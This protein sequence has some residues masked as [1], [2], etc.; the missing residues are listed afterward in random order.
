[1]ALDDIIQELKFR[2]KI[3]DVVSSYNIQLKRSSRN[4]VG[5]CPFHGEKTPSFNLYPENNSFYCFGCH[6]GGDVIT[7]IR[8]MENLDYVD[9][10]K[11]LAQRYNIDIP[12]STKDKGLSNLRN[13]IYEANKEAARYF[14][15]KL[16]TQE[17]QNALNYLKGRGLTEQTIKHF[18]LGYSTSITYDLTSYLNDKGF[19]NTELIQANLSFESRS[20][21]IVDRFID[22]IM[23]PIMDLRGNVIAFGGRIMTDQKPKYLNTSDTPV[24]KKSNNCFALSFA[25]NSKDG[26]L[27]LAEGYMDVI[28][29]HQAGFESA[30]ATLGTALTKEQAI[31]LKRYTDDIV[32]CYDSDDAGQNATMRAIPILRDVGLNVRVINIPNG[33]DPDEFLKTN[34]E[35]GHIKFKQLIEKSGNDIEYRLQKL[36]NKLDLDSPDGKVAY[37]TQVSK[38]L[39]TFDSEIEIDVYARKIAAELS[40]APY[41]IIQQIDKY[42][43]KDYKTKI[44]QQRNKNNMEVLVVND[45]INPDKKTHLMASNAEEQIISCIINNPDIAGSIIS[46]F[47]PEKFI[48]SF[49]KKIYECIVRR[50]NDKKEFSVMDISGEFSNDENSRIIKIVHNYNKNCN[51]YEICND[52]IN[53]IDKENDKIAFSG[54]NLSN[55]SEE[56]VQKY[57]D[58]LKKQ[59]K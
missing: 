37:L 29:L 38:L 6:A 25:K 31:L 26:Y 12:E 47:P 27:I 9:A 58:R 53:V 1:M 33:K 55:K 15:R 10:V 44:Q 30:I 22:R 54:D 17:G 57:I 59:K 20:G 13:R 4:L 50:F 18:G 14:H 49:N 48:T 35:N 45:S 8:K 52:C 5:L 16:Y 2:V 51:P 34:G 46:K 21:R 43:Q 40:V 56:D 23:F 11:L 24:F 41:S 19:K 42:K 3:E 28:A 39:A 32:L 36:K 7:F